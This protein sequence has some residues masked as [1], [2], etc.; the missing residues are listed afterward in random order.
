MYESF[1]KAPFYLND[2][3]IE[4]VSK[5]YSELTLEQKVGQLFNLMILNNS[6]EELSLV[7]L[8]QPGGITKFIV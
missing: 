6:D 5:T 1:R 3:A 2:Q 4:W 8:I 7:K